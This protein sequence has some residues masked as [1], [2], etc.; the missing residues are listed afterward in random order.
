MQTGSKYTALQPIFHIHHFQSA[1]QRRETIVLILYY[2]LNYIC[3]CESVNINV[4]A[5]EVQGNITTCVCTHVKYLC[6]CV[7]V[8]SGSMK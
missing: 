3:V 1:S 8:M 4:W 5:S 7:C 6:V 2:L